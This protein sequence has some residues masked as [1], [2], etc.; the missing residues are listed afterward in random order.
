MAVDLSSS[1]LSKKRPEQGRRGEMGIEGGSVDGS[2]AFILEK[3]GQLQGKSGQHITPREREI[4]IAAI[5]SRATGSPVEAAKQVLAGVAVLDGNH[6]PI[7]VWPEGM[8]R[9]AK[10]AWHA[11]EAAYWE[12]SAKRFAGLELAA[13]QS[14]ARTQPLSQDGLSIGEQGEPLHPSVS[15]AVIPHAAK[16]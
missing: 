13:S 9:S 6:L 2:P 7:L 3:S 16:K 12:M 4:V 8:T 10:A 14:A 15:S 11:A 1:E 5:S